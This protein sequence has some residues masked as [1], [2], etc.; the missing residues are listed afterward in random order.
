M[1]RDSLPISAA[2]KNWTATYKTMKSEHSLTSYTKIPSKWIKHL[3][4]RQHSI[5]LREENI[6]RELYDI[7]CSNIFFY[8]LLKEIKAK[9][10]KWDLMKHKSICIAKETIDK[11]KMTY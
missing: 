8:P 5:K 3:T 9:I 1:G 7:N 10:N 11:M 2:G 6:G 4:V